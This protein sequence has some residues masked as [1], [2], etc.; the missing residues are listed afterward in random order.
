[1][2][3]GIFHGAR[4]DRVRLFSFFLSFLCKSVPKHPRHPPLCFVSCPHG[5]RK[6]SSLRA[7]LSHERGCDSSREAPLIFIFFFPFPSSI[8]LSN[9]YI[10]IY[11]Y[12]YNLTCTNLAGIAACARSMFNDRRNVHVDNILIKWLVWKSNVS[13]SQSTKQ[14]RWI[15]IELCFFFFFFFFLCKKLSIRLSSKV[16]S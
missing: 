9:A 12:L 5:S 1:M 10:Y 16:N 15:Q 4:F 6:E 13:S 2:R 3:V 11:L 14:S 7:S 8:V